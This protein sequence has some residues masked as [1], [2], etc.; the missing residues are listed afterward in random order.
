MV[1][2]LVGSDCVGR[3]SQSKVQSPHQ[4]VW[5][6]PLPCHPHFPWPHHRRR[7]GSWG[8]LFGLLLAHLKC[9]LKRSLQGSRRP[10]VVIC[11]TFL[12]SSGF[13]AEVRLD[14]FIALWLKVSNYLKL[15]ERRGKSN[16]SYFGQNAQHL[17][18]K[19]GQIRHSPLKATKLVTI[20]LEETQKGV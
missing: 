9:F 13:W 5:T 7:T 4:V 16:S 8:G 12:S 3:G 6:C 15:K 1:V 19:A 14:D 17:E 20:P 18:G 2:C 11:G 10:L